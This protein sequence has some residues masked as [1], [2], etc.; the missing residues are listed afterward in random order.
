MNYTTVII[1]VDV[2][3]TAIRK[4]SKSHEMKNEATLK[5]VLDGPLIGKIEREWDNFTEAITETFV[6]GRDYTKEKMDAII[7]NVE[8]L[9][10]KAGQRAKDIHSWFKKSISEFIKEI[11]IAAFKCVPTT[12]E[13]GTETYSV[14]KLNYDQ[15]IGIGGSLKANFM[16]AVS[17][18][19]DGE[20]SI[21]VEYGK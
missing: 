12:I 19:A 21:G 4:V 13:I 2:I 7:S 14:S 6:L 10:A 17:L 1:D 5:G 11:I 20:M 15:K 8:E 16:E 3:D 9:I 18:T